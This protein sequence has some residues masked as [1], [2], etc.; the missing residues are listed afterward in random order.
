MDGEFGWICFFAQR[1]TDA[2]SAAGAPRH[3]HKHLSKSQ[4]GRGHTRETSR[5]EASN[6]RITSQIQSVGRTRRIGTDRTT[7]NIFYHISDKNLNLGQDG[8][9]E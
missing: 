8:Y 5:H 3:N 1:F 4:P 6:E 7:T 9:P 2:G